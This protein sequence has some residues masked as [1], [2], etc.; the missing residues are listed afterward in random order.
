[1]DLVDKDGPYLLLLF[2]WI[3]FAVLGWGACYSI[4]ELPP[5]LIGS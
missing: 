1:M 3:S 4:T 2:F 5:I